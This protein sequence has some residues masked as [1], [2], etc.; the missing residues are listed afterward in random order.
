MALA[1]LL[2][3]TPP[4]SWKHKQAEKRIGRRFLNVII[5]KLIAWFLLRITQKKGY[6]KYIFF[7]GVFDRKD[8]LYNKK[9]TFIIN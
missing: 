5:P 7:K 8:Y 9:N 3:N 2:L 4:N 6:N 1:P